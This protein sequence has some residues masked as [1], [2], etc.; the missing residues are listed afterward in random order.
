MNTDKLTTIFGATAFAS[1][2]VAHSEDVPPKL[3]TAA[4]VLAV[5]A[6]SLFAYFTNKPGTGTPPVRCLLPLCLLPFLGTGCTTAIQHG[7]IVAVTTRGLGVRIEAITQTGTPGAVDVGYFSSTVHLIPTTRNA[8]NGTIATPNYGH[9]FNTKQ[10]GLTS[11]E[12]DEAFSAGQTAV[13]DSGQTNSAPVLQ[14]K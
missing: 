9:S 2:A 13:L 3:R 8:T 4:M 12:I 10:N 5:V 11:W 1:G 6:G 7:D 14:P